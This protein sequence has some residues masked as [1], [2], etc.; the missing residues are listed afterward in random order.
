MV[1]GSG[2]RRAALLFSQQYPFGELVLEWTGF[3]K[4]GREA[5]VSVSGIRFS[6]RLDLAATNQ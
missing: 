2:L 6:Y 4:G 3:V 5:L 1:V